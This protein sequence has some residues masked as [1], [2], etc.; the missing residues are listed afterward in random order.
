MTNMYF[1][2][3]YDHSTKLNHVF[4]IFTYNITYSQSSFHHPCA[5][6]IHLQPIIESPIIH[7]ISSSGISD[8]DMPHFS[9]MRRQDIED[10]NKTEVRA[11]NNTVYSITARFFKGDS[12]AC[13][14]EIGQQHNGEYPCGSCTIRYKSI[15][16][17]MRH[18]TGTSMNT[19]KK[20]RTASSTPET[21]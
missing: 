21:P 20:S 15:L 19:G 9:S 5:G 1:T 7:I 14:F 2:F 11:S 4:L 3:W 12:V 16:G 17:R 8:K 18:S 13:A 10:L 6:S